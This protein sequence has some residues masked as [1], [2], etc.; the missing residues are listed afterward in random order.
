MR[1]GE[2]LKGAPTSHDFRVTLPITPLVSLSTTLQYARAFPAS[3]PQPVRVVDYLPGQPNDRF[4]DDNFG[5]FYG[6]HGQWPIPPHLADAVKPLAVASQEVRDAPNRGRPYEGET[7]ADATALLHF[8]ASHKNTFGLAQIAGDATPRIELRDVY[9]N[10]F[11]L[12]IG[13]TFADRVAFWNLRSRDPAFLGGEPTTI[14]VAPDRLENADFFAALAGFL[15]KRNGVPRNSGTP[16]VQLCSTSA[17]TEQLNALRDRFRAVDNWNSYHVGA[18][19]T[20]DSITPSAQVLQRPLQL[21][22]GN[23]FERAPEWKE[24]GASGDKTQPPAVMP[25]HI[26]HVQ[27][28]NYAT[29]GSW[30]LDVSIERQEN[31]SRYSNVRHRWFFP[32]R[33]R[34]HQAFCGYYESKQDGREYRHTRATRHGSLALFAGFGE[35]LPAINLPNDE[36]AFRY[37]MQRGDTWA[38]FRR[39]DKWEKPHGP[40]AWAQPS[41]KGRYLIGALRMFGGLQEAGVVLLHSYWRSIFEEIGGAIGTARRARIKDSIKKKVRSVTTPP[42]S[43]DDDIWSRM[44]ALVA[45]EAHQVRIPQQSLSYDELAKKHEPF[46]E[47]EREVLASQQAEEPEEWIAQAK[48]SLRNG[49]QNRCAQKVLFQGYQWRCDVCFNTNWNDLGALK[50]ELICAICGASEPAPVDKPWSF[51]LNGFLKDAMREHGLTALEHVPP[52]LTR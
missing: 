43:W 29:T 33:L 16:C 19:L 22:T 4:I 27:S 10:A 6:S 39:L 44:A 46:L 25:K 12:V 45:S 36:H 1:H 15:K 32:R 50:P 11:A 14:M 17:T 37:A 30:A 26:V 21:V 8:M 7:V 52:E 31:H 42:G 48:R 13:D 41:D 34:F 28:K 49:V 38:P 3:A 20:L 40:F 23:F 9:D 24:F 35:E 18:P 2:N 5:T 51:Q 47:K